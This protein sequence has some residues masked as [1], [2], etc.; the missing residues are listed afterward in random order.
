MQL[1]ASIYEADDMS[2]DWLLPLLLHSFAPLASFIIII[3]YGLECRSGRMTQFSLHPSG[4]RR[5][6]L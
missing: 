4:T 2:F 3:F 1:A 6:A 5:C